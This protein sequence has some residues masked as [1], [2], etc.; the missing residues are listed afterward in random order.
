[1]RTNSIAKAFKVTYLQNLREAKRHE[2]DKY[3]TIDNKAYRYK[4]KKHAE[5]QQQKQNTKESI[6]LRPSPKS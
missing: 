6:P 2:N 3:I 1:M 4:K 5:S